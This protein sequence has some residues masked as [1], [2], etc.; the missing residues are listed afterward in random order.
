MSTCGVLSG[1]RRRKT[2]K[3]SRKLRGG[4]FYG[5]GAAITPG[6]LEYNAVSGSQPYSSATGSSIPDP[7]ASDTAA[8][9]GRRRKTKKSSKRKSKR[10]TRKSRMRGGAGVYN[11]GAVG[12]GFTGAVSGMPGSQTYGNYSAYAAKVPVGGPTSGEDGVYRV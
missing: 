2:I 8:K 7:Y 9:G 12:T 10:S 4:V 6:A 5:V 1:G 11:A 3:K